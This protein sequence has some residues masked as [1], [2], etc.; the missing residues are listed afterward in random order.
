MT[1]YLS[2][3]KNSRRDGGYR[4]QRFICVEAALDSYSA[5]DSG[6]WSSFA[7][8]MSMLLRQR[9]SARLKKQL[10]VLVVCS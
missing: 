10:D 1:K 7:Y 8:P 3:K 9:R 2:V 5:S 6:S 4:P